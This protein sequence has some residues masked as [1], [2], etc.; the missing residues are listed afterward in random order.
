MREN[1]LPLIL[2]SEWL[3]LD[4]IVRFVGVKIHFGK[5]SVDRPLKPVVTTGTFDGVHI[6]HA[7]IVKR[8]I[9]S[10]ALCQ[11]ESVVVTFDPHPRTVLF[12]NDQSLK[13]LQSIDEKAARLE[14]LGV[15]H[16]LVLPF[17]RKFAEM[18]SDEYVKDIIVG[19]IGASKMV[20]GYDH[21]FGKN[22][23]GSFQQ[24][25]QQGLLY[26]FDVEEIPARIIDEV[27]VSSSRIR[28]ALSAGELETAN[29]YLGY[30][31]LISGKVVHGDGL[32]K[33]IGFPTA[34][35]EML[36]PMKLI[37]A[38]GVYAVEVM[39]EK[40]NYRGM[41]NIG[42]RPTVSD[43]HRLK[44]EVHLL[45]FDRDIYGSELK[46]AFHKRLRDE[47]KFTDIAALK[48]QLIAD[49]KCVSDYF[50]SLC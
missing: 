32:G 16:L 50:S 30:R 19:L 39:F 36:N 47:Q 38:S 31:Y 3:F 15:Q 49:K 44:L 41:M 42:Y 12:P 29:A 11:G 37:P 28:K 23:E 22:R 14:E 25:K 13:L 43:E 8:L 48:L 18:S 2:T 7:E 27:T 34:N 21:Q 46:I 6:G 17:D 4:I 9:Q 20:I 10:A 45:D 33:T 1:S 26:G 35:I 40:E 5:F 24:L